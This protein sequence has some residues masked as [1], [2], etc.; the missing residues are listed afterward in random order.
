MMTERC[1]YGRIL[2]G[3]VDACRGDSGGPLAC[4]HDGRWRLHGVVSWGAGCARRARP[5]V[6]TRVASY[7]PWI[8]RTAAQLGYMIAS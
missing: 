3:G 8:Q 6:Y 4:R 2:Q 5:G 7:L 1:L